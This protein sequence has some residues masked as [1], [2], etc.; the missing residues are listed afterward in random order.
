MRPEFFAYSR[1]RVTDTHE[2]VF[3][4]FVGDAGSPLCTHAQDFRM[5]HPPD[6]S[7]LVCCAHSPQKMEKFAQLC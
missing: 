3:E 7:C 2:V 6:V 5:A 4:D 1:M